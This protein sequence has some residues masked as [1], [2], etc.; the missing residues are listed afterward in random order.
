M[1]TS[2]PPSL[3]PI[4]FL[5][6]GFRFTA[7]LSLLALA[8]PV[9]FLKAQDS[10]SSAPAGQ[11]SPGAPGR[12]PHGGPHLLPPRAV[13]VLN[14]TAEQKQQLKAL[15]EE[16]RTRIQGILTPAQ[17]DQLKQ[18]RPPRHGK[19]DAP[20]APGGPAAPEASPAPSPVAPLGQASPQPVQ[21][22]N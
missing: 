7:I 20:G 10:N 15:E 11:G 21:P 19:Q 1:K 4:T 17:L 12:P 18:M 14:L 6:K 2:T 5:T 9:S 3:H 16:V 8:G 13:E 22:T